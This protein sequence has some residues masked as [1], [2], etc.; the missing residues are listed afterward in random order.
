MLNRITVMGRLTKEPQITMKTTEKGTLMCASY[1]LACSR[2]KGSEQADFFH[3]VAF[4]N[5]AK[6]V[7]KYFKK[8]QLVVVSGRVQVSKNENQGKTYTNISIYVDAQYMTGKN[9]DEEEANFQDTEADFPEEEEEMR[10]LP[11]E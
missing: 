6:V 1:T 9:K 3:C 4:G 7:E 8:G 10:E 5:R 2:E 11:E